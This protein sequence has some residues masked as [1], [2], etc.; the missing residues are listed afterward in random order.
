MDFKNLCFLIRS[1]LYRHCPEANGKCF[2]KFFIQ[3]RGF[4]VA[5]YYR[6]SSYL[7][8]SN[9]RFLYF[10]YKPF[11]FHIQNK[12]GVDLYPKTKIDSGFFMNH[13]YGIVIHSDATLGKNVNVSKGV[14][15]GQANRGSKAGVPQI[16]NNV[17]IGPNACLFGNVKVGNNVAIGANSVVLSDVPDNSV[18]AGI[19]ARVVSDKGA[20]GYVINTDYE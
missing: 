8:R 19:P 5:F 18:V 2:L 9:K 7:L 12:Y 10:L 6:I 17:F 13:T 4:K 15:I 3:N 20:E 16:G 11:L 14:V 1:D